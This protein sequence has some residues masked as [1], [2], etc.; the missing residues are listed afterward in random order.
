MGD[1]VYKGNNGGSIKSDENGIWILSNGNKTMT[2]DGI[3]FSPAGVTCWVL[4]GTSN[5][6]CTCLE[7]NITTSVTSATINPIAKFWCNQNK[8]L[9]CKINLQTMC[10]KW[11]PD[12][13][14]YWGSQHPASSTPVGANICSGAEFICN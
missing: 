11:D 9:N 3:Y 4:Q 2:A 10:D 13:S 12:K 14:C 5:L 1:R 8:D 6:N 7:I